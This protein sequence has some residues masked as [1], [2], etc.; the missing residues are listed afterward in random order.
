MRDGQGL[1]HVPQGGVTYA[2][3]DFDSRLAGP[4]CCVLLGHC[5][6]SLHT[7][8][9]H[10]DTA[11]LASTIWTSSHCSSLWP[12]FRLEPPSAPRCQEL[13]DGVLLPLINPHPYKP[14]FWTAHQ[15]RPRFAFFSSPLELRE[16]I[17]HERRSE[18]VNGSDP[19]SGQCQ[20]AHGK[21]SCH[22]LGGH[23]YFPGM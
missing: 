16:R 14:L 6:S 4:T 22:H 23:Y 9:T 1:H 17:N 12:C 13:C 20:S 11:S 19:T 10:L 21:P 7:L 5:I 8:H 2:G 3:H 18:H 15:R